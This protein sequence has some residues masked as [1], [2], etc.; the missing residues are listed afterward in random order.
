MSLGAFLALFHPAMLAG[1]GEPLNNAARIFA[2]YLFSRNL[3]IAALLA[4][5]LFMRARRALSAL[6]LLAA[7]VQFLDAAVDCREQRW[8]V[9]P[10]IVVLGVAFL[11]A[12]GRTLG[13]PVWKIESWRD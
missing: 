13:A 6:T 1:Q 4:G 8:G 11:I 9:V 10:G 2:G 5:S 12:S 3:A 7:V